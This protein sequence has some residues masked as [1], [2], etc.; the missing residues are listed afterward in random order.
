MIPAVRTLD[1]S[2]PHAVEKLLGCGIDC[3]ADPVSPGR[4]HGLQGA[5]FMNQGGRDEDAD[6]ELRLFFKTPDN[7]KGYPQAPSDG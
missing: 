2:S 3:N 6:T 5:F 1:A 4:F 7:M